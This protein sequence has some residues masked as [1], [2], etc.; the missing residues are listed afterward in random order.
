MKE[1]ELEPEFWKK[2]PLQKLTKR[3]WEALCMHCGRCCLIKHGDC[4]YVFFTNVRCR[5]LET[6]DC[7]CRIYEQRL[8]SGGCIEVNL[9]MVKTKSELLPDDCAYKLLVAGKDLPPW[10]PL[11]SGNSNSV[12]QAGK[13]VRNLQTCS[14]AEPG[15]LP[16]QVLFMVERKK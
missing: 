10:H 9:Q 6:A 13:S 15:C 1:K 3:E 16:M 14:E 8:K 12:F 5:H 4:R 11:V 7:S 2:K